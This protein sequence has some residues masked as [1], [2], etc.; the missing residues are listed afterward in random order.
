MRKKIPKREHSEQVEEYLELCLRIY[1]KRVA[2]GTWP[3]SVDSTNTHNMIDSD[4]E[5]DDV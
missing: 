2:D 1:E 3:W 5:N 4:S